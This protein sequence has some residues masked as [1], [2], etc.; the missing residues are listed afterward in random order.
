MAHS[1]NNIGYGSRAGAP[2]RTSRCLGAALGRLPEHQLYDYDI[3]SVGFWVLSLGSE[4][5]VL[6]FGFE[7]LGFVA[8]GVWD[9]VVEFWGLG[10]VFEFSVLSCL[11][12]EF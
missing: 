7:L 9:L 8:L 10:V 3:P 12:F 5:W 6:G 11:G 4:L 2:S 1:M